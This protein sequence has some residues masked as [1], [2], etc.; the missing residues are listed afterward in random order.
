MFATVKSLYFDSKCEL[1]ELNR[2]EFVT[3]VTHAPIHLEYVPICYLMHW[4]DSAFFSFLCLPTFRNLFKG[5]R[6]DIQMN[7]Y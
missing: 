2:E 5:L 7:F 1:H 4:C 3:N 6:I